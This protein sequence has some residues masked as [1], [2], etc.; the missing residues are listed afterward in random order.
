MGRGW[1]TGCSSE[2]SQRRVR[3]GVSVSVWETENRSDGRRGVKRAGGPEG[4]NGLPACLP[5]KT[6]IT[7]ARTQAGR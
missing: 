6:A 3:I 2:G 5:A 4:W 1:G 7:H